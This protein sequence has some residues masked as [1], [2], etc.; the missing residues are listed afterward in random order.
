MLELLSHVRLRYQERK[1]QDLVRLES[2]GLIESF[3]DVPNNYDVVVGFSHGAEV[4]EQ[5]L[6]E[7]EANDAFFR[8]TLLAI[9]EMR[10]NKSQLI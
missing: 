9:E 3:L 5:L 8:L 2:C 7:R 4:D 10:R 1:A 6:P